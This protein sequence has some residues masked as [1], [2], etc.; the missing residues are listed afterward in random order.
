M[1][2]SR[3]S[4][5][6][7]ELE[8]PPMSEYDKIKH[9]FWLNAN[10]PN[11]QEA[12]KYA[13]KYYERCSDPFNDHRKKMPENKK[14]VAIDIAQWFIRAKRYMLA[15]EWYERAERD[16]LSYISNKKRQKYCLSFLYEEMAELCFKV[17][18]MDGWQEYKKKSEKIKPYD[19]NIYGPDY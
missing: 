1:P 15:M 18:D 3:F 16:I 10:N 4:K 17:H 6:V 13:L 19:W 2:N 12:Q 8:N 9:D 14:S 7:N 5:A 11:I